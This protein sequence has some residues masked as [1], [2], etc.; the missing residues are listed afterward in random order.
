MVPLCARITNSFDSTPAPPTANM[1]K[2]YSF[3]P[4]W[5]TI[6]YRKCFKKKIKHVPHFRAN[7]WKMFPPKP[8]PLRSWS[9]WSSFIDS[10]SFGNKCCNTSQG[11]GAFFVQPCDRFLF[12]FYVFSHFFVLSWFYNNYRA[13][14]L[15]KWTILPRTIVF[16]AVRVY[17]KS[18][19]SI[20]N[21]HSWRDSRVPRLLTNQKMRIW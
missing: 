12:P 10:F 3:N 7:N 1:V 6:T 11:F 13:W 14:V 2:S 19:T 15:I 20:R 21:K 8:V 16:H 4:F 17:N 9:L 5:T 18:I